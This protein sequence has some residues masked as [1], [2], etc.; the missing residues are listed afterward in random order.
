M[1]FVT[2]GNYSFLHR[3]GS[4]IMNACDVTESYKMVDKERD[5]VAIRPLSFER[6]SPD[7]FFLQCFCWT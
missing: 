2:V 4:V 3:H 1:A 7:C 6:S 5:S